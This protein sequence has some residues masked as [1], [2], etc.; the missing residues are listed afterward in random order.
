M[1]TIVRISQPADIAWAAMDAEKIPAWTPVTAYTTAIPPNTDIWRRFVA[2][3]SVAIVRIKPTVRTA[4]SNMANH[5][6]PTTLKPTWDWVEYFK[7]V[8]TDKKSHLV[9]PKRPGQPELQST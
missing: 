8:N 7:K 2:T 9:S 3:E 1:S 5:S 4:W 6:I